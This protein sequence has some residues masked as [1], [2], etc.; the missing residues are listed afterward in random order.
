VRGSNGKNKYGMT[1]MER[2]NILSKANMWYPKE[3]KIKLGK[4]KLLWKGL[5]TTKESIRE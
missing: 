2:P 3:V 1:N 5:Y 4:F